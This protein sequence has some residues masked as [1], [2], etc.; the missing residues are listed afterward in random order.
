MWLVDQV[1]RVEAVEGRSLSE[2]AEPVAWRLSFL[3]FQPQREGATV[4]RT[5]VEGVGSSGSPKKPRNKK[6]IF[7]KVVI[8]DV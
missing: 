3:I 4:E 6:F 5:C 7:N 2:D 8:S 1:L